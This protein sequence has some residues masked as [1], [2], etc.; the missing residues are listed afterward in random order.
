MGAAQLFRRPATY[1]PKIGMFSPGLA[2]LA[3]RFGGG[4]GRTIF[5]PQI[6]DSS[7][8]AIEQAE[9]EGNALGAR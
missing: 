8:E 5:A 9:G 6:P 3:S 7:A 4:A 1:L 2:H